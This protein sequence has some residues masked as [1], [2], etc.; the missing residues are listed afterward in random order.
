MCEKTGVLNMTDIIPLKVPMIN[1][2]EDSVVIASLEVHEGAS[3][4][5][6]DVL[7]VFETTKSTYEFMAKN[8]GFIVGLV[9]RVGDVLG[10]G[11]TWAYIA[12]SLDHKTNLFRAKEDERAKT[13][14]QEREKSELH[15]S[16]PARILAK[17]NQIDLNSLPQ[18]VFITTKM[19]KEIIKSRLGT[20]Q[21]ARWID[22]PINESK[23]MFIYG[24]GGHGRSLL[25]LIQLL[26][27][28][29]VIGFID[30]G[31]TNT[32]QVAEVPV[33]GG[34]NFL[35]DLITQQIPLAANGIGG[36]GD[37]NQRM[38]TFRLLNDY[39][40]FCPS[41]V[42]PFAFMENS[43]NLSNGV[44]VF[45]FAYVGTE[46]NIGFGCII[47]TGAIVSHD[48]QLGECVNLSPGATIAGDVVIGDGTLIGMRATVN[49]GVRI[50]KG[51]RVGN[52]ATVK[53]D[54]PDN[55]IIPAGS[56]WPFKQ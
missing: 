20:K 5:K 10:A 46:V 9:A 53:A 35:Q 17:E 31:I 14:G 11:Q 15:I 19:I 1:A 39:G 33:L 50:G 21:N 23:K 47:N 27:G 54:I 3:I 25:E 42:H 24:A 7:A 44:Q 34:R 4:K 28:Y 45:P 18:D 56:I 29:Q 55:G 2:N 6:G 16:E 8:D 13:N 49:L 40:F 36:I 22:Q 52:G 30:D 12:N 26:P 43:A 48:C 51:V 32:Q 41:F 38:D 37:I